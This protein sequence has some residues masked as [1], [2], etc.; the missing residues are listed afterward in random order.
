MTF[1]FALSNFTRRIALLCCHNV[2][3]NKQILGHRGAVKLN[4]FDGVI[5]SGV[6][7]KPQNL[8]VLAPPEHYMHY[9]D[10]NKPEISHSRKQWLVA[11]TSLIPGCVAGVMACLVREYMSLAGM[12]CWGR[13]EAGNH[14]QPVLRRDRRAIVLCVCLLMSV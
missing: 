8:T 11:R 10:R 12:R 6:K 13:Q 9:A 7:V 1:P 5:K 4:V 3:D 14:F 2:P